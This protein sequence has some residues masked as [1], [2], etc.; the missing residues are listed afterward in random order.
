MMGEGG[1]LEAL[2]ALRVVLAG[3]I[4]DRETPAAAIPGLSK[5]LRDTIAELEQLSPSEETPV[6]DLASRRRARRAAVQVEASGGGK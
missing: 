6:D 4:E 3:R 1:R 2:R 5:Q